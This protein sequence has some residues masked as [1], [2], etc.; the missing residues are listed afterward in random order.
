MTELI[1]SVRTLKNET[2]KKIMF[3]L[4]NIYESE[5]SFNEGSLGFNDLLIIF[6]LLFQL[7]SD[8]QC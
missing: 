3:R 6:S 1:K 7:D 5:C 2:Y 8:E 4:I